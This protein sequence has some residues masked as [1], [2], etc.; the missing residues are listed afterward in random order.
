MHDNWQCAILCYQ[1]LHIFFGLS[2]S[3]GAPISA[4]LNA[5]HTNFLML[6]GNKKVYPPC[7][8]QKVIQKITDG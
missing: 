3:I 2:I 6:V 7:V 8:F 1:N 4:V 5:E